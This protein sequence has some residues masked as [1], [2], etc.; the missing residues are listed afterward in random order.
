MLILAN[1][2]LLSLSLCIAGIIL[3]VIRIGSGHDIEITNIS[4]FIFKMAPIP[5]FLLSVSIYK[6]A[7]IVSRRSLLRIF[8]INFMIVCIY[9]VKFLWIV[10]SDFRNSRTEWIAFLLTLFLLI[11]MFFFLL[12]TNKN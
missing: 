12:R 1:R 3:F 7:R 11:Q 2:I 10:L 8:Y 4:T 5:F 6:I 9:I